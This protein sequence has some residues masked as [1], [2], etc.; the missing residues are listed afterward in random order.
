M[1]FFNPSSSLP[2]PY[3]STGA[4]YFQSKIIHKKFSV[5]GHHVGFNILNEI[6]CCV[7]LWRFITTKVL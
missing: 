4:C 6:K 5:I 1:V 7:V 2:G 3:S